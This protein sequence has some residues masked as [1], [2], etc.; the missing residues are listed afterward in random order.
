MGEPEN[1]NRQ[2]DKQR[3]LQDALAAERQARLNISDKLDEA[4]KVSCPV[5]FRHCS[6]TRQKGLVN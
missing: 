2:L 1:A 3:D 6:C 4:V 5:P